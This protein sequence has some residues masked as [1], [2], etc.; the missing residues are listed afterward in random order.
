MLLRGQQM[1]DIEPKVQ[2]S[3]NVNC[4]LL[5]SAIWTVRII[6]TT[7]VDV[8]RRWMAR[9]GKESVVAYTS[10]ETEEWYEKPHSHPAPK[11]ELGAHRVQDQPDRS[12]EAPDTENWTQISVLPTPNRQTAAKCNAASP[13]SGYQIT[14]ST[15][16]RTLRC[17]Y[18]F[19]G[20]DTPLS[21][22]SGASL[23]IANTI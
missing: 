10:R 13:S 11:F 4:P 9:T 7:W 20:A 2:C 23:R 17:H 14:A 5:S 22:F 16:G 15:Y 19:V 21:S 8:R 12:K 6:Q 3:K 18:R 1:G